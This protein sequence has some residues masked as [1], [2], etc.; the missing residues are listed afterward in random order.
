MNTLER[1][2]KKVKKNTGE[3][4]ENFLGFSV[5]EI[6]FKSGFYKKNILTHPNFGFFN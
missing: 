5:S 2:K 6:N 1:K 4:T 3:R